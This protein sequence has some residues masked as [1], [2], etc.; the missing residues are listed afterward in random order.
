MCFVQRSRT[1][2]DVY[3]ENISVIF[4]NLRALFD[5]VRQRRIGTELHEMPRTFVNPHV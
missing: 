1:E 2:K 4:G 3:Q 5:E